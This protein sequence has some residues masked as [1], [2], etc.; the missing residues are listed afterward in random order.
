MDEIKDINDDG[1][2][3]II[4]IPTKLIPETLDKYNLIYPE[5]YKYIEPGCYIRY[6]VTNERDQNVFWGGKV[7]YND[8]PNFLV[9]KGRHD[10]YA[11]TF[12]IDSI[13]I[14]NRVF[15][16]QEEIKKENLFKLYEAGYVQIHGSPVMLNH[17]QNEI[18]ETET[19]TETEPEN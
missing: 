1:V 7:L 13:Y 5:H 17:S 3:N 10:T 8:Y 16:E 12:D 6:I 19:E 15:Y 11:M 9:I 2:H 4:P 14:K 18:T